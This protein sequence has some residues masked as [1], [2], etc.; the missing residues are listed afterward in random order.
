M[1]MNRG[2]Y[3]KPKDV[4]GIRSDRF[5]EICEGGCRWIENRIDTDTLSD[6]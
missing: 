5:K 6:G 2:E 1:M 3:V 4:N